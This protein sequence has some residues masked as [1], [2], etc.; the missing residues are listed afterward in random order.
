MIIV[1]PHQTSYHTA[2]SRALSERLRATIA[3][4][5]AREPKVTPEEIAQA[6]REVQQPGGRRAPNRSVAIVA[7]LAGTFL[8]LGIGL[9]VSSAQR[10][11][12]EPRPVVL[13]PLIVVL[14][15]A[16]AVV[17]LKMRGDD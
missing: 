13:L 6:L 7:T 3:E 10:G 12:S 15:V 14:L 11:G 17:A 4:F 2:R 8:A 1:P 5:Q 16:V 9:F